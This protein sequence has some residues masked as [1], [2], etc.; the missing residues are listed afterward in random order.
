MTA[1]SKVVSALA[2]ND[3]ADG[4]FCVNVAFTKMDGVVVSKEVRVAS[5][6]FFQWISSVSEMK[7]FATVFAFCV[8]V[9]VGVVIWMIPSEQ[10]SVSAAMSVVQTGAVVVGLLSLVLIARQIRTTAA[11]AAHTAAI[12]SALTYHQY[13]GDL[14]TVQ[15]RRQLSHVSN[16]CGFSDARKK[17]E[18]MD[19]NAVKCI[20]RS[21]NHDAVVAQYLDEFEEF[22]GAIHAKLLNEDYAYGLEATRIIRTW[23]VFK[24]YILATRKETEDFR[25]YV[26]LE[27]IAGSWTER[28]KAEDTKEANAKLNRDAANGIQSVVPGG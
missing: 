28:R 11:Q 17:G 1:T 15:V 16:T 10:R 25:T 2:A 12:N 24:P 5:G 9:V 27:R 8:A 3:L 6:G 26:E 4:V 13:F 19:D 22:C 23:A 14:I 20:K 21:P 7:G 18:P